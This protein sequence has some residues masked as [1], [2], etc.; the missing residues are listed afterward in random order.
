MWVGAMAQA[1]SLAEMSSILPIAGAQYHWTAA[2][3]P[4]SC[5]KFITWIQGWLTWL[6]WLALLASIL[7]VTVNLIQGVVILND[8]DMSF[9]PWQSFLMT[10][11]ILSVL[12]VVNVYFFWIVPWFELFS[13]IFHVVFFFVY[14]GVLLG[15]T[16]NKHSADFVFFSRVDSSTTSGWE[17]GVVSWH[18]GLL[19]PIWTF[20]GFD[21]AVHLSEE[22]RK[23]KLAVPRVIFW[24]I[25]SNGIFAI[26]MI[27]ATLY[28]A[29]DILDAA[30]NSPFPFVTIAQQATGSTAGATWMGIGLIFMAFSGSLG[31]M[32]SVSRLT[33]AW[34]RD[35]GFGHV[36]PFFAAVNARRIP[37]RAVA[38]PSVATVILSIPNVKSTIAFAALTSL[39]TLAL[40]L[41]YAV[42]IACMLLN[43][44]GVGSRPAA[45]GDWNLG[46][47]GACINAYAIVHSLYMSFWLPWPSSR[48][49]SAGSMN[50]AGPITGVVLLVSAATYPYARKRWRSVNEVVVEKVVR[51]S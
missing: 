32:V 31:S 29:G 40:Y 47:W 16:K 46:R 38:L 15:F 2:L 11:C 24:S 34:A 44:F 49:T 12:Y 48:P 21:A 19:T 13:G 30:L 7:S 18:L 50:W 23:A 35:R 28:C 26:C 39:S 17:T 25:F 1:A 41:S 27:I 51:E 9:E 20:S 42:A 4:N 36:S 33:W 43:R 6:A 45:L 37:E 8:P 10:M 5:R 14:M 22:T 3:A